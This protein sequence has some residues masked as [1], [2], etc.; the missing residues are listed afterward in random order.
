MVYIIKHTRCE[1]TSEESMSRI[2][3]RET[4][5]LVSHQHYFWAKHDIVT[6]Q[7]SFLICF[8]CEFAATKTNFVTVQLAGVWLRSN[9]LRVINETA[10]FSRH[11]RQH[12]PRKEIPS[13]LLGFL[14]SPSLCRF[15]RTFSLNLTKDLGERA[16]E[17]LTVGTSK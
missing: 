10:D 3:V 15:G 12:R 9:S 7:M 11:R 1:K 14:Y 4:M 2:L 16:Q 6:L 13:W 5:K 8:L 17:Y